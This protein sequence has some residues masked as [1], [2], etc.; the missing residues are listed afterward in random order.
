L[1]IIIKQKKVILLIN[2]LNKIKIVVDNFSTDATPEIAKKYA[3]IFLQIGPERSA[4]RNYGV[5]NAKGELIAIIDSDMVL[6]EKVTEECVG[7]Y[8]NN[9]GVGGIIVPEESFGV[10]FWAQCKKLERSYYV[11]VSWMEAAR[12][13]PKEIYTNLGGYNTELVS[14]EDWDLSQRASVIGYLGRI[15]SYIYHNE[16][17]LSL[18]KT[19]KKKYYYATKFAKYLKNT[20]SNNANQQISIIKRYALFFTNPKKIYNN[21]FLWMG[22]IFM[23]TLEFAS[24]AFGILV[25]KVTKR[26]I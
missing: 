13:F 17:N 23:K 16:G 19:L 20:T 7:L 9:K 2:D 12:V 3:D 24:G 15:K 8:F 25:V 21:P 10:G 1:S 11:G 4:Q 26:N 5:E 14:G 22:M 18:Y 6:S